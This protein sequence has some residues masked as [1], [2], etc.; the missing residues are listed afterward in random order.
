M[1]IKA[2]VK[3]VLPAENGQGKNGTW[4]KQHV[5]VE[6]QGQYKKSIAIIFWGDKV[7]VPEVGEECTFHVD[8]ESR[9]YNGKWYTEIRCWKIETAATNQPA[10][11]PTVQQAQGQPAD[12]SPF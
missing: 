11:T 7:P 6:T 8:P 3:L 10:Y 12:D 1:E 5:I 4:K 9:E 2:T